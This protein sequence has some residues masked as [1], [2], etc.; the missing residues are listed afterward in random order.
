MPHWKMILKRL[1][2]KAHPCRNACRFRIFHVLV[3]V[4]SSTDT[5]TS[6]PNVLACFDHATNKKPKTTHSIPVHSVELFL[7]NPSSQSKWAHSLPTACRSQFLSPVIPPTG[8]WGENYVVSLAGDDPI[9]FLPGQTTNWRHFV[10]RSKSRP[11]CRYGYLF[12]AQA[13]EKKTVKVQCR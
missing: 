8:T 13:S 3:H 7:T 12:R 2:L 4:C 1:R 6:I 9:Q 10:S 11:V 5:A